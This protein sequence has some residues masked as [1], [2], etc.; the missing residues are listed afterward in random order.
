MY[1][2]CLMMC[3]KFYDVC[4]ECDVCDICVMYVICMML[5]VMCVLCVM[6]DVCV[7]CVIAPFPTLIE[8]VQFHPIRDTEGIL[9]IMWGKKSV[10]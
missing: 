1:V 3:E 2:L 4:D 8:P 5:C 7:M 9:K 10:G 6:C